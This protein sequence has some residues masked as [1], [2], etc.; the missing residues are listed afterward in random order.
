LHIVDSASTM[1]LIGHTEPGFLE[2]GDYKN[3]RDGIL[4]CLARAAEGLMLAYEKEAAKLGLE[5]RSMVRSG[6][7]CDVIS[8][9]ARDYDLIVIGHKPFN[10]NEPERYRR[11]LMRLSAAEY[12]AETSVKPLLVV[13]ARPTEWKSMTLMLSLEHINK[14][15]VNSSLELGS[16]LGL[17]P[18]LVCLSTS[19]V[20]EPPTRFIRDVRRSDKA[21]KH[22]P[23]AVVGIEELRDREYEVWDNPTGT[24][25]WDEWNTTLLTVPTRPVPGRRLTV[26]DGS[27]SRFVRY[28]TLPVVLLYPEDIAEQGLPLVA[29]A[30]RLAHRT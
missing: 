6:N 22:V 13:Q 5:V 17:Q 2:I 28:T 21:L 29:A 8:A 4:Q 9:T 25:A 20:E 10:A 16:Q 27:P 7:P 23:I 3:E 18:T 14:S 12:L 24:T 26:A 15:Y 30:S 19:G 11:Q 1:E